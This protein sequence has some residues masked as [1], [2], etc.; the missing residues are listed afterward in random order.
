M[1]RA[2]EEDA[3]AAPRAPLSPKANLNPTRPPAGVMPFRPPGAGF[4]PPTKAAAFRPPMKTAGGGS[5]A[6]TAFRAP[7][8]APV[9]RAPAPARPAPSAPSSASAPPSTSTSTTTKAYFSCLYAKRKAAKNR[10]SKSWLDGICVYEPPFTTLL[11]ETGKALTKSRAG[12][13]VVGT[14]MDIGNWNVEVADA[15]SESDY[16]S[17]KALLGGG[18]GGGGGF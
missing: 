1:K 8:A 6:G 3:A 17:G 2:A 4:R 16:Q 11:D 18:G 13:C 7:F 5:G 15:I 9:A 10:S 12:T 14:E